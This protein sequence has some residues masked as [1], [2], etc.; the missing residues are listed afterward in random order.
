MKV[1]PLIIGAVI[2]AIAGWFMGA[3]SGST[4]SGGRNPLGITGTFAQPFQSG[5]D[6]G[7]GVRGG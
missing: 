7:K 4:A 5:I 3:K 1:K 2:G 6:T